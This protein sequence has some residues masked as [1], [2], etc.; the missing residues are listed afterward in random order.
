MLPQI[1]PICPKSGREFCEVIVSRTLTTQDTGKAGKSISDPEVLV[2][3]ISENR[4]I[5]TFNR[6]D[7][8]HLHETQPQHTGII[9]STFDPYFAG[10]AQRI[11]L[12][13]ES[14]TP[15]SGRLLRINRPQAS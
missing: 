4:A 7:F 9:V 10:L 11:H 14:S 1:D 12:A 8:I 2:F 6:K 13:I 5:L 3:A 15:L